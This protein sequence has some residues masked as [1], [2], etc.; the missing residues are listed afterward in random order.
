MEKSEK[1]KRISFT[2]IA[3]S[4]LFLFNPSISIIDVLPDFIGYIILTLALTKLA[5]MS[6]TFWEAQRRFKFL[7]II[8]AIKIVALFW[9]FSMASGN[10]RNSSLLLW[11]FVFAVLD[12]VFL[13]PALIK[14]FAG[15][16]ELAFAHDSNYL[17]GASGKG[18]TPTDKIRK[19]SITFVVFKAVISFCP[20][21]PSLPRRIIGSLW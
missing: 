5:D 13:I 21:L 17:L 1:T 6:D 16:T 18:K 14:L 15:M 19:L 20:S 11:S 9:S 8:D 12:M 10:E 7:I 3:V 4:F 2:A